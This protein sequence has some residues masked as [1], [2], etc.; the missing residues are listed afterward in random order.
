MKRK[1]AIVLI[2]A[3]GIFMILPSAG[4]SERRG[5]PGHYYGHGHYYGWLP[6]A[7]IAGTFLT[8]AIIIGAANQNARSYQ[9]PPVYITP[10]PT[11]Y[12]PPS[13]PPY[14]A[15]DP[16]Y[17]AKYGSNPAGEWVTIPGQWVGNTWVPQHN[18]FVQT[19]P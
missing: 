6:A 11:V 4:Y 18:V 16:D 5:Y 17:V 3:F 13:S 14:A 10:G 9:Q 8:S 1:I 19:N 7:I 15:P 12:Y 2:F